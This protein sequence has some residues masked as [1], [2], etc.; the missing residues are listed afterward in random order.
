MLD[1]NFVAEKKEGNS[2]PPLPEDMYQVE[3]LDVSSEMRPTYDT[4]PLPEDQQILE[5]V[6]NFHFVLLDGQEDGKSLR[7]RSIWHKFIPS[8]LYI[9]QKNGKN[10]LYEVVE[11]LQK[12]TVSPEQ[13]AKGIT[14]EYLNSL[15][16]RQTRV[17]TEN[18]TKGDKT[19]THI[20][21]FFKPAAPLSPLTPQEKID[22]TPKPKDGAAE[23]AVNDDF[24]AI[25]P[26]D[27]PFE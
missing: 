4:R 8:Y 17:A 13:E 24:D 6:L 7:G 2:Y 1:T 26:E 14:G 19:Y 15:I 21:K 10:K 11:A 9:S 18:S 25:K 16:G 5:A 12:Q 3:L 22:A 27:I 20:V 23:A